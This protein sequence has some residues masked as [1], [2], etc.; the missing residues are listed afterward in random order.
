MDNGKFCFGLPGNP[1]STFVIFEILVKPFLYKMMGVEQ[2]NQKPGMKL[3][4]ES[5][6]HRK[7]A[8]RRSWVPVTITEKGGVRL[9]EYHG[10]GHISASCRADGLISIPPG[11]FHLEAGTEVYIRAI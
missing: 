8:E 5:E 2:K 1:V 6:I 10:P 3:P 11:V 4:L 7:S 9:L